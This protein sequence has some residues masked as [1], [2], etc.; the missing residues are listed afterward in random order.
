VLG[1]PVLEDPVDDVLRH[2]LGLGA[3]KHTVDDLVVHQAADDRIK[4]REER[5]L[6]RRR[7]RPPRTQLGATAT[8]ARRD[9]DPQRRSC[10]SGRGVDERLSGAHWS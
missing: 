3:R 2:A 10:D 9:D 4:R 5:L 8:R 7:D 1:D 6:C